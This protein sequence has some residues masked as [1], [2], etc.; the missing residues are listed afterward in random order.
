MPGWDDHV[1]ALLLAL[2]ISG[3]GIADG[4]TIER[5]GTVYGD[6]RFGLEHLTIEPAVKISDFA[7]DFLVTYTQE[8]PNPAHNDD[9]SQ[10]VGITVTKRVALVRD[11]ARRDQYHEE[12]LRRQAYRLRS[13]FRWSA[14]TTRTSSE[15]P[16]ALASRVIRDLAQAADD[17]I[18]G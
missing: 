14:T 9:P 3:R 7:I 17:E 15:S 5:N 12:R 4:A 2:F 16:F 10:P 6:A 18:S 11:N 13:A 1:Q 8:G